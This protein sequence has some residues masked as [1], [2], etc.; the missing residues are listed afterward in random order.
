M[1]ELT[2]SLVTAFSQDVCFEG[3]SRKGNYEPCDL[4]AVAVRLD[5][6]GH[7]YPVCSNHVRHPMASM[8]LIKVALDASKESQ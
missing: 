8:H 6:E 5:G 4:T 1:S 3:V 2:D 7:P